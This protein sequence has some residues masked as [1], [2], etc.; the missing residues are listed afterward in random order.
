MVNISDEDDYIPS[1]LDSGVLSEREI[2][3][4]DSDVEPRR[5]LQERRHAASAA[6]DIRDSTGADS[7]SSGG[8]IS[9]RKRRRHQQQDAH[10]HLPPYAGA[11]LKRQRRPFNPEYL[12]VLNQDVADAAASLVAA[13]V[14]AAEGA[15]L[16]LRPS[17]VGAVR[18]SPAE[19]EA[20]FAALGRLG[21][22][23]APGI[24]A[25]VGSKGPLE[26]RQ[27]VLLLAE[28]ARER[29]DRRG[30]R[31]RTLRPAEVPAAAELSRECEAALEG[32]ADDLSLRQDGYE[33][34]AEEKRWGDRW[35]VTRDNAGEDAAKDEDEQGDMPFLD[36][37]HA[38][39]W[40]RLS[41]RLFMN[42]AIPDY[43]WRYVSEEP[44]SIRATAL[45]DFHA[46]AASVT[47]RLVAS[48]LFMAGARLKAQ[49]QYMPGAQALVKARDVEAAVDSLGLRASRRD[50]WARAPR[51]LRLDVVRDED[52]KVDESAREE[53][54]EEQ[55]VEDDDLNVVE[56]ES[57]ESGEEHIMSFHDVEEALGYS[58]QQQQKDTTARPST[59]EDL[60]SETESDEDP[61][62]ASDA[63]LPEDDVESAL[64]RGDEAGRKTT[65]RREIARDLDEDAVGRDMEEAMFFSA[66]YGFTTRARQGLQL[67]IETEHRMEAA[68]EEQ[69]M[70]NSRRE[71]A[72]LQ[73]MI[74]R[75][76]VPGDVPAEIRARNN[77]R[78]LD[79]EAA[80]KDWRDNIQYVSEWEVQ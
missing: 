51:R 21:R 28:R 16:A 70:L 63:S 35:L 13:D 18:W 55:D 54:G 29:R 1:D 44:P 32:A 49:R 4:Q 76:E 27:L 25:R 20:L 34:S 61:T 11:P 39:A 19:K 67:R 26:V 72:R 33:A 43:N 5:R 60:I 75:I 46:L 15:D 30:L 8:G 24:A 36:F 41:D 40:L 42:S 47:R 59:A 14:A 50:F 2:E 69:D 53:L 10:H 62:Y 66:D 57:D 3:R 37:F 80:T 9:T 45:S 23:D 38:G 56:D 73:A 31:Q 78:Q 79:S 22:D 64:D 77:V 7:P 65:R 12:G 68:A 52:E 58:K 71:E 48:A 74:K 17:Q 6:D